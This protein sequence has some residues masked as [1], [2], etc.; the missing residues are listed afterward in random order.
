MINYETYCHIKNLHSE[1]K[2]CAGQIARELALDPRTVRRVLATTNFQPRKRA[3]C[4]LSKLEP[5]KGLIKSWIERHGYSA[6][7]ILQRLRE[8]GFGGSYT[9]VKDYV[10]IIRPKTK[11][12]FLTLSFAPG[13]CAQVDWGHAG[14]IRIGDTTRSLSFFLMVLCY[15]RFMYLEFTVLQT[16][17]HFLGCHMNAFEFFGG[18]PQSI[19]VDYVAG[20]IINLMCPPR[21]CGEIG[22]TD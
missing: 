16:M 12:A 2:L 8:Q 10:S 19:M 14:S 6:I 13:E 3:A 7:Q 18:V 5:Y 17:E 9:I 20:N 4:R 15:S 11:A 22:L 1:Q 21:L